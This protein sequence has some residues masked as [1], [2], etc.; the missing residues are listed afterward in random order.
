MFQ[1]VT[2]INLIHHVP[3]CNYPKFDLHEYQLLPLSASPGSNCPEMPKAAKC[4]HYLSD[5]TAED[6]NTFAK[7]ITTYFVVEP[8]KYP[9]V[10]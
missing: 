1:S 8:L 10:F 9:L 6:M 4:G 2:L 5:L 7:N 3:S